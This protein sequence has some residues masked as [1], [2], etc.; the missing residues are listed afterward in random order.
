MRRLC[1]V[2]VA[3]LAACSSNTATSETNIDGAP[4]VRGA[5]HGPGTK[6][7]DGFTV[8]PG[9]VLIGAVLPTGVRETINGVPSPERGWEALFLVTGDPD[10][11]IAHYRAD[12]ARAGIA[13]TPG[14]RCESG[15]PVG[16]MCGF[17]DSSPG[18]LAPSTSRTGAMVEMQLVRHS[19]QPGVPPASHLLLGFSRVI[20]GA[21]L[22]A[23]PPPPPTVATASAPPFPSGWPE[24]L[25][26]GD[27]IP[28]KLGLVEQGK[29]IVIES[30]TRLV[31]PLAPVALCATG[32]FVAV[33]EVTGDV[34]M[35]VDG[36]ARQFKALSFD[37]NPRARSFDAEV[38]TGPA[39]RFYESGGGDL[40][41]QTIRQPGHPTY[42]WLSRCND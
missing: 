9:S 5:T 14:A 41:A 4:V 17:S 8:A 19:S 40:D 26:V 34:G 38:A 32:G 7:P 13:S 31:A 24:L 23:Q 39:A 6:L 25:K 11:V 35:V 1:V 21:P 29:H 2:V 42:L 37:D 18:Y 30:G 15:Q 12:A 3:I 27:A 36:Y 16:F 20:D 28:S 22:T 10:K 33:F